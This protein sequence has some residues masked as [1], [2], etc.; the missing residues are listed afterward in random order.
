M[1]EI[2]AAISVARGRILPIVSKASERKICM[3]P[4]RS[5][6]RNTMATTMIPMPP[7]HCSSPRQRLIPT[8]SA[9]S[10]SK[11]VAP[12]VVRP[13]IASKNAS[14]K[15]APSPSGVIAPKTKGSAPKI[16]STS[17]TPVVRKKVCWIDRPER[18]PVGAGQ[19]QE[20][21]EERRDGRRLGEGAPM[22][23][24]RQKVGAKRQEHGQAKGEDKKAQHVAHGTH[25]EHGAERWRGHAAVSSGAGRETPDC[26]AFPGHGSA[27]WISDGR[28]ADRGWRPRRS[29][30][31]SGR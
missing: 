23:V 28:D 1:T 17:Q 29:R 22:A 8:G 24:A 11:A 9:S 2:R 7:N 30:P 27:A 16:G 20:Q 3:P 10:P 25:V 12:V 5:S 18:D 15:R 19:R 4:T 31:R 13:D 26:R 14:T 6:G 21:A